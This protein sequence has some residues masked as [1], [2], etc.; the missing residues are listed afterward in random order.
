VDLKNLFEVELNNK[1]ESSPE[2]LANSDACFE[3]NIDNY[4]CHLDLK[5]ARRIVAG[6][7]KS[8]DCSISMNSEIFQK[9][10]D[11]KL[12]IPMALATRK[13]KISGNLALFAKL[14]ELFK[15]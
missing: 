9:L 1:I 3:M 6:K 10:L 8:A 4:A 12:N 7:A 5:T 14:R 13:I 15:S 2:I 11:G